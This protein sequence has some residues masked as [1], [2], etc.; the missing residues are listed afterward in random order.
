MVLVIY[1][2]GSAALT[3]A[4][5]ASVVKIARED[6]ADGARR[7]DIRLSRQRG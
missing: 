1:L 5:D 4:S 3:R 2:D 6:L 7:K